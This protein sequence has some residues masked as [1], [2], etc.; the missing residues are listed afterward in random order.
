MKVYARWHIELN[1]ECPKCEH[2]FDVLD[3][4]DY[5]EMIIGIDVCESNKEANIYCPS[6]LLDFTVVTEY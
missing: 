4:T 1:V 2:E 5:Q 3:L 6:C